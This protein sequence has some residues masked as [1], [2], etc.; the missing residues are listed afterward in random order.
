M[1]ER[2]DLAVV[3]SGP[4]GQKAAIAAAKLGKRVAIIDRPDVLGGVCLHTGTIPSKTFREAV[5]YLTGARMRIFYGADYMLKQRIRIEDLRR[6]VDQVVQRQRQVVH[7]QLQRNGVTI[8]EGTARFV[9][10]HTLEVEDVG[11]C[12]ARVQADY[13]LLACGTRPSRRQDIPFGAQRHSRRGPDLASRGGRPSPLCHRYR[14]RRHRNGI[15]LHV[16]GA[17]YRRHTG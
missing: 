6:W 17:E 2:Y 14:G 11:G 9:A 8:V 10:L 3:G 4:A 1:S 5:L 13:V 15:R 16:C 7:D 12:Q